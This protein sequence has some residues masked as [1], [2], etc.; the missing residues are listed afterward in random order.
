MS[1]SDYGFPEGLDGESGDALESGEEL[2]PEEDELLLPLLDSA[3][4][5]L[6]APPVEE[7]DWP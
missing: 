1:G 2:V 3:P 6:V 5:G 4:P 7:P